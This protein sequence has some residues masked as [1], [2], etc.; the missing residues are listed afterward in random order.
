MS[1]SAEDVFR[2]TMSDEARR[3]AG[4][5]GR[6][7]VAEYKTL[8]QLRKARALTQ[9]Q[10]AEVLR[11]D[12]VAISQMEKRADMLL[13]T[14]RSYIEAMGGELNLV[15]QFP[16]EAPV[17]LSGFGDGAVAEDDIKRARQTG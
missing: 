11:K 10:L 9:S 14:L 1:I 6:V 17:R 12:Q 15:V 4:E 2:Q 13:S 8:Q 16:D 3:A 5:R 7:L